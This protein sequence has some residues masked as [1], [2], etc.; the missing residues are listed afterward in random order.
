MPVE[1]I[2][3]ASSNVHSLGHDAAKGELFVRFKT[4]DA[5]Y[6]YA[7]VD[8]ALKDAIARADSV[9]GELHKRITGR[10]LHGQFKVRRAAAEEFVLVEA[11]K[12]GEAEAEPAPER[13]ASESAITPESDGE[14]ASAA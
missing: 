2:P 9:G 4:S 7:G 10:H 6:V 8:V 3:V 1:M 12:E 14:K 11:K 5:P 13:P